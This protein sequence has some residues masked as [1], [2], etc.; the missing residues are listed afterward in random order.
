MIARKFHTSVDAV[1]EANG[2]ADSLIHPGDKL[3][4]IKDVRGDAAD[5]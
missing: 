3:I 2:L 1:M 5:R 4:V